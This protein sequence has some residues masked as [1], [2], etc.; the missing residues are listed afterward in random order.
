VEVTEGRTD[1]WLVFFCDGLINL[2]VGKKLIINI[3]CS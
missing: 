3:S 1:M 2:H